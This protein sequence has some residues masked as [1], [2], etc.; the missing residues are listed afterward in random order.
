MDELLTAA[1]A[2]H[3]LGVKRETVYAYVSRGRLTRD[4]ASNWRATAASRT[5]PACCGA[6]TPALLGVW[7]RGTG[8]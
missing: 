3:R 6:A 2:A 8:R 5:S 1:E 7:P 4:P